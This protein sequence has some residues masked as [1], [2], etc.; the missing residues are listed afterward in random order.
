MFWCCKRD[1]TRK[2]PLVCVSYAEKQSPT[3]QK[4][5]FYSVNLDRARHQHGRQVER[6]ATWNVFDPSSFNMN[7]NFLAVKEKKISFV[8]T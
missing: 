4:L 7:Y 6:E 2:T 5:D 1:N 8:E 3:Q